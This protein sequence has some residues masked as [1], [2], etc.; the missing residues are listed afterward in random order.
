MSATTVTSTAQIVEAVE[1][2]EACL[3]SMLDMQERATFLI[4]RV[5]EIARADNNGE[6]P[7]LGFAVVGEA[8]SIEGVVTDR[9]NADEDGWDARSDLQDVRDLK[10]LVALAVSPDQ[11]GVDD[12][13]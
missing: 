8:E 1:E 11:E 4:R 13:R 10:A 2:L 7:R 12:G 6:L 5:I 3:V 9:V